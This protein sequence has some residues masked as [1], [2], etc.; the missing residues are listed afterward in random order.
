M[1]SVVP[2]PGRTAPASIAELLDE[3][4][5]P[6][7]A[8]ARRIL[9]DERLAEDV[10]QEA[11]VAYWRDPAAYD[12][13]RGSFRSWFLALVHHKAVD[14]VR[15][16][17]SQQRRADA[18]AERF[19]EASS[20]DV[21]E[22]VAGRMADAWVRTALAEL[23]AAQ[24]EALV[25]A[26]WGG[27]TQREIAQRTGAPLGTVKT[28]MMVGMRRLQNGLTAVVPGLAVRPGTPPVAT[29]LPATE[30]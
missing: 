3:H 29:A 23:P 19:R 30:A 15:H 10:V 26:Y 6:A 2:P 1:N 4:T 12:R 9:V 17:A 16:E 11:F 18:V 24:R 21:A 20:L 25:L 22:L 7:L 8:L 5:A 14:V 28:R 13:A 27:Y